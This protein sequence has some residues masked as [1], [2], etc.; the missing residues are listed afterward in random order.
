MRR[1]YGSDLPRLVDA[2]IN[3]STIMNIMAATVTALAQ[4]EP[5]LQVQKVKVV[6]ASPGRVEL[7]ITGEYLP[8]GRQITLNGIEIT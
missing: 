2:P 8:E 6:T 5:R 7:D 1:E 4:W 3:K